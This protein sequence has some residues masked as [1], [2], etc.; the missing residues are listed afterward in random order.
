MARFAGITTGIIGAVLVCALA[1]TG[2]A[3]IVKV[4]SPETSVYLDEKWVPLPA[5]AEGKRF[6][7]YGART[8]LYFIQLSAKKDTYAW[9]RAQDV[10]VDWGKAK[11]K[12]ATVAAVQDVDTLQLADGTLV[13][14]RR[15]EVSRKDSPLTRQTLSWLKQVLVGKE[16]T[17]EFDKTGEN[18]LGY[19]EAYVYV[20]GVFLNRLLVERGL[21]TL[22]TDFADKGRYDAVL[23]YNIKL[24]REAQLGIWRE[25]EPPERLAEREVEEAPTSPSQPVEAVSAGPVVLTP[26]QVQQWAMRLQVTI[27]IRSDKLS[28]GGPG[29]LVNDGIVVTGPRPQVHDG[30]VPAG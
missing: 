14:F 22:P 8:G 9:I 1:V 29:P 26:S 25:D 23:S 17:L 19:P 5:K 27:K 21:A 10:E 16:V 24:A 7:V 13:Q 11:V 28:L 20:G 18:S 3:E 12:T 30:V 15:V 2:F 6:M 4:T